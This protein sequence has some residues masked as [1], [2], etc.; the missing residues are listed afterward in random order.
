LGARCH[1]F[2]AKIAGGGNDVIAPFALWLTAGGASEGTVALRSAHLRRF[3]KRADLETATAGDIVAWLGDPGLKPST[4]HSYRASVRM[5]YRWMRLTGRREDDPTEGTR[6]IPVPRA[7]PRPAADDA[8][9]DALA[10]ATQED[11]LALMLAALA[12][13]RRAEIAGL[14]ADDIDDTGIRVTGKG[15]V[16]RTVPIH[17]L[18]MRELKPWAAR[19]GYLFR[20]RDGRGPVSADAMGR[21]ISRLLDTGAH[22]LRHKFASDA[23]R[24][25]RDIRAVQEL[26]GHASVATTQVY[27]AVDGDAL[28]AA[29]NSIAVG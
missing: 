15:G 10:K 16:V 14:H 19:G 2:R 27:V 24:G 12:G 4:R 20:G 3:G 13:L 22:S 9:R 25:T 28:S 17:P 11:R 21:R 8:V 18:L 23:Y 1:P 5:F 29:V 6:S 7:Q 26:L